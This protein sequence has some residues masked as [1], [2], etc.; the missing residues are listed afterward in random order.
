VVRFI[1]AIAGLPAGASV[2]GDPKPSPSGGD[3]APKDKASPPVWIGF[4]EHVVFTL[5]LGKDPTT[6]TEIAV[7]LA[8]RM[9]RNDD[10][11]Q[12]LTTFVPEGGWS[13]DD[14]LEQC[15]NDSEHT[16]GAVIVLPPTF[17]T[18]NDNYLV[19]VRSAATLQF[20]AMV[21][22]CNPAKPDPMASDK[23]V[24][25][26]AGVDWVSDTV[27]GQYGRSVIQ[28]LPLAVLTSVYLA[29]APQRLYQSVATRTYPAPNPVP[30][31]GYQSS[32]QTESQTTLNPTG[33]ASLQ[34]SVV[35]AVGIG[36]LLFGRQASVEHFTVRAAE[37]A[38][39]NFVANEFRTQCAGWGK[40]DLTG[41]PDPKKTPKPSPTPTPW[42]GRVDA[43]ATP[44]PNPPPAMSEG[45]A[46]PAAAV[47]APPSFCSW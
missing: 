15:K 30:A 9:K 36:E 34:N 13:L 47:T 17:E 37:D 5:A 8:K 6:N 33:T 11:S 14:F 20:N 38:A 25:G 10:G 35:G 45:T 7:A 2:S 24:L 21:A 44:I 16:M 40:R 12:R 32:V 18:R 22:T 39:T 4:N 41:F 26:R 27:S 28:F 29:F 42:L 1:A 31:G 23:T 19:M 46:T 3:T 43:T